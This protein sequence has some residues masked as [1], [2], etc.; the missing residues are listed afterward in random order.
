LFLF[1][2][3]DLEKRVKE[4]IEKAD[5]IITSG[6]VS[7]GELDLL[8][9]LLQTL[10]TIHFGRVEMKVLFPSLSLSI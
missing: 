5:V 9:P 6:G 3:Q 8:K 1:I 10:G 4:G 7:M 2:L